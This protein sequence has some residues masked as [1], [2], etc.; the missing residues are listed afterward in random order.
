MRFRIWVSL[1]F[2]S[3]K[4]SLKPPPLV[5]GAKGVDTIYIQS[6]APRYR[7]RDS[8][9]QRET[10]LS[11]YCY[12][13]VLPQCYILE[14]NTSSTPYKMNVLFPCSVHKSTPAWRPK[15]HQARFGLDLIG[16]FRLDSIGACSPLFLRKR[17]GFYWPVSLGPQKYT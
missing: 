12:E 15:P 8:I 7:L 11:T 3:S 6:Q 17:G 16:P 2:E 13:L 14:S 5:T 4:L 9:C 1:L 10:L